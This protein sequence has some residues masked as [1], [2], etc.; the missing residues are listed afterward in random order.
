MTYFVY[1][2]RCADTTLYCGY[3]TDLKRR[4][5]EH[6]SSKKGAGYTKSRRPVSLVYSEKYKTLSDALKREYHIK[7]LTRQQKLS[8]LKL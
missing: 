2:L 4:M 8:L 1:I 6:N 3:T 7:Q 5:I